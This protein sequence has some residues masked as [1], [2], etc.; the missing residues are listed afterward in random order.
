VKYIRQKFARTTEDAGSSLAQ[1]NSSVDV[2]DSS[3]FLQNILVRVFFWRAF[4]KGGPATPWQARLLMHTKY[5]F[6]S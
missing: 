5:Y 3:H 6:I 1:G 2:N 4:W